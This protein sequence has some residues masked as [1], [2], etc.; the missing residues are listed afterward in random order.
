MAKGIIIGF[1]CFILFFFHIIIFRK[2]KIRRRFF[3]MLNI[4]L[5]AL[6][7]YV[8][9]FVL[10]PSDVIN[11]IIISV[12]SMWLFAFL[13][14]TFL[15]FFIFYL[16]LYFIQVMDRSPSTRIMVDIENSC[17]G[18]MTR[19]EIETSCSFD[20]KVADELEDMVVLSRL[21][22]EGGFYELTGKGKTHMLI[23]KAIRDYLG[24]RRS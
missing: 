5:M 7:I 1:F 2:F 24:L 11:R 16:Y 4:S 3:A 12:I 18:K 23:F 21:T 17:G 20:Q 13:S 6:A 15:H 8:F 10:I 22:K 14:G 19:E 9:L